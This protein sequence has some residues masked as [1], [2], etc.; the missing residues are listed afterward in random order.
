VPHNCLSF[1]L[2]LW[3][4]LFTLQSLQ[5]VTLV[6]HVAPVCTTTCHVLL[7]VLHMLLNVSRI[8]HLHGTLCN[9]VGNDHH[10]KS[11]DVLV[12]SIKFSISLTDIILYNS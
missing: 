11:D 4:S 12:N 9:I 6:L 2:T 8:F 1:I 3:L 7:T 5:S 10:R